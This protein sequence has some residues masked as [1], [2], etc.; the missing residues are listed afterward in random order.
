VTLTGWRAALAAVAG[1][2]A[3]GLAMPPWHW[4]PLGVLGLLAYVWLWDRA[5]T[6][7]AAFWR[8]WGWGFGHFAIG[9][10]WIIEAFF[11]PPAQ[12]ALAGPP[13][14]VGPAAILG[15]FPALAAAGARWA[16]LRRPHLGIRWRRL[17]LLAL[18]WMAGEWL[19]GHIL[20]GYPWN[21]LAHV[22]VFA[23]PLLQGAALVGVYGLGVFTFLVLA[24]PAAGWR[25]S[26]VALAALV[27]AGAA[28]VWVMEP[29]R[30][31]GP[32]L[33]IVQPNIAQGE[34]WRPEARAKH[35][36]RLM[37]LSRADGWEGLAAVIWPETA[38][39]FIV[40]PDTEG[41]ALMATAAPPGGWLLA[42]APRAESRALTAVWNSLLAIDGEGKIA[43][44]Y[45]KAHLV[46][47]GEYVPLRKQLTP[48]AG[49]IGRG[50]FEA[51][52]GP[53]TLTVAGLPAFS[54]I[55]CYEV[56]FPGAVAGADGRS[57]WL[58]NITNDAWF[59]L[60]SGPHQHLASARLRAIEE[61]LPMMR[62]ANTGISA[63]IDPYGR[64]LASLGMERE[65]IIDH[66]LP[67]ARAA[68]PYAR[69]GDFSL[70]AIIAALGLALSVRSRRVAERSR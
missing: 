22:F 18:L 3:T 59:G 8:G 61:G 44:S 4:L 68:T 21:P 19:R 6:P 39:P 1:G 16:A 60:S 11:V 65:G 67:A 9:S 52:P 28:G 64:I 46:P 17:V 10:Y 25:A 2:V 54:P 32:K 7:R 55:I 48:V 35:F 38:V 70:L 23:E 63:V 31:D 40:T 58:L 12:W 47:L 56:I 26:A 30:L 66:V 57:R 36:A 50:S 37:T 15:L 27:G 51:G 53:T 24:A 49:F 69:L 62:A 20:S 13:I 34:K 14:V 29:A 45:D 43:A 5:T 42:G 41:P 33:R